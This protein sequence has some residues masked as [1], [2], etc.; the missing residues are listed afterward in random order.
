MPTACAEVKS[1][2]AVVAFRAATVKPPACGLIS[3]FDRKSYH[4]LHD[5][6]GPSEFSGSLT[7]CH[8]LPV[9][10]NERYNILW[11]GKIYNS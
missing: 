6:V 4:C 7:S 8:T 5:V 10:V 3:L 9:L 1:S 2:W 11:I